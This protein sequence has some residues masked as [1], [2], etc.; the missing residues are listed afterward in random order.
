MGQ[1]VFGASMTYYCHL[2][3]FELVNNRQY[4]T[5]VNIVYTIQTISFTYTGTHVPYVDNYRYYFLLIRV[6]VSEPYLL[7]Y[8]NTNMDSEIIKTEGD[9]IISDSFGPST[10]V[11]HL[12][13]Y[14]GDITTVVQ[15]TWVTLSSTFI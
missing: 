12:F 7:T 13:V 2:K 10:L 6:R 5:I 11:R 14:P 4:Y 1:T 8:V 9:S 3:T 15:V